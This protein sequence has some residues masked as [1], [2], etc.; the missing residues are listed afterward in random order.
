MA[1]HSK[2]LCI[3]KTHSAQQGSV[4]IETS[5]STHATNTATCCQPSVFILID[6]IYVYTLMCFDD[7][8]SVS[9]AHANAVRPLTERTSANKVSVEEG[10]G[11]ALAIAHENRDCSSRRS[12]KY[13]TTINCIH[14]TT[15]EA[16]IC[17]QTT[18]LY[19]CHW[20]NTYDIKTLQMTDEA[21]FI[22]WWCIQRPQ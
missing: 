8:S 7:W 17:F 20:V 16:N 9:V 4:V 13:F 18:I 6:V 10:H 11:E 19:G 12:S 15:R 5:W 2:L 14:N 1:I 3:L 21:C 22:Q